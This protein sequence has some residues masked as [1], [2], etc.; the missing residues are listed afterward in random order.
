MTQRDYQLLNLR[1]SCPLLRRDQILEG[2]VPTAPTIASMMA[3]LEVQEALKLIHG[4]PVNAGSA[5][6]FNGVTNQFYTTKLPHRDDC[7]SHETYPE[8]VPLP[9]GH[10][11][12]ASV[13]FEH[14]RRSLTGP[15]TLVLERDLVTAIDCP[16]CGWRLEVFRPRTKVAMSEAVCPNCREPGRP[17]IISAIEDGS[18][19]AEQPLAKLGI[20]RYD[21]V[22]VD[23][24][25]HT[26]FFLLNADSGVL[27]P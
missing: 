13:L 21:I 11:A 27:L 14:A 10:D 25:D 4:L 17:E 22:R 18:P 20:P 16:R 9:I 24:E 23:G 12:S 6:V 19:L 3:A 1:Y 7:L 2:K 15:L 8:P 5:M 26:G